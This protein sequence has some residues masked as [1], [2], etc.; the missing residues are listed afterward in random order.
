[1]AKRRSTDTPQHLKSGFIPDAEKFENVH[2]VA[3]RCS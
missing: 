2:Q 3:G 1:M